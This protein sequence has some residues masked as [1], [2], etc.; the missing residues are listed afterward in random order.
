[1]A[2]PAFTRFTVSPQRGVD[3]GRVARQARNL[4]IRLNLKTAPIIQTSQGRIT[5]DVQREQREFIAYSAVRPLLAGDGGARVLAGIDLHGVPWFADL[6]APESAHILVA[7]TSG[8][9]KT[10]WLATA[11]ASLIDTNTSATLR[12]VLVDPKRNA[13]PDLKES[14]FLWKSNSLLYPPEHD[15]VGALEELIEEMES[16]Y[17][18]FEPARAQD[19]AEYAARTGETLPRIV[20]VFDE[21]A[22]LM[23][24]SKAQRSALENAVMRLGQKARAAGIHLI[25]ATQRPSRDVVSGILRANLP[26]RVALRVT[27]ALE[28]RLVL[29]NRGGAELLLGSGDL[30]FLAQSDPVRLQAPYLSPEERA[31]V[32]EGQRVLRQG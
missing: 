31:A 24:G 19:L 5:I 7:G 11:I 25:V 6:A 29:D 32:F 18:R 15:V 20:C 3:A 2:G 21:Y 4:Q 13:F 12:L 23:L 28:S 8:S 17:A 26:C 22:D 1:V 10:Q 9:G 16:R 14:G 27:E 30:L